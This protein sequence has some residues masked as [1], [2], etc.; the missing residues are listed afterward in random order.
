MSN[1]LLHPPETTQEDASDFS[2]YAFEAA[3]DND[4][5]KDLDDNSD[6]S[7]PY[8]IDRGSEKA[9]AAGSEKAAAAGNHLLQISFAYLQIHLPFE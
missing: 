3:L 2:T 5:A 1:D 8:N 9:A 4:E 7:S 6:F